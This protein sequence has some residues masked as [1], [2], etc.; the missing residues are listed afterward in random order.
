[1]S[2]G[3]GRQPAFQ[4]GILMHLPL[5]DRDRLSS[6]LVRVQ[7][8]QDQVLAGYN[9]PADCFWFIE[10]GIVSVASG[11]ADGSPGCQAAMIGREGVVGDLTS[12][13]LRHSAKVQVVAY[14]PGFAMR[15]AGD[16]MEQALAASEPLQQSCARFAQSVV[17]QVM[18]NAA[19]SAQLNVT[20]RIARW[21]AMT[22]DRIDGDEIWVTHDALS[23]MLSI[24]RS[25]IA[26]ATAALQQSGLI[27]TGRG[28][29][30]VLDRAGLN[31]TA[32]NTASRADPLYS[33]G[34]SSACPMR[35]A[36]NAGLGSFAGRI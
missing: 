12:F 11:S 24:R 30:T 28:R 4:N 25:S 33:D 13:D 23:L 32:R 7:F 9:Q 34:S 18:Q 5:A 35:A 26:F 14:L 29:F 1:M 22:H 20:E 15:I 3:S 17:A 10:D 19:C 36:H 8:V 6:S 31:R 2:F 16:K 27:R 21:M